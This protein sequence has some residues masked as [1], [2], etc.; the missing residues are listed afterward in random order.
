M[1]LVCPAAAGE[2]NGQRVAIQSTAARQDVAAAES[3]APPDG[4]GLRSSLAVLHVLLVA[5]RYRVT[6]AALEYSITAAAAAADISVQR[7]RILE[8]R[9]MVLNWKC[10]CET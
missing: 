2:R 3:D 10:W 7:Y 6:T 4:N 1:G 9:W 5:V 8:Y